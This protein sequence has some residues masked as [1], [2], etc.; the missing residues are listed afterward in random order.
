MAYVCRADGRGG[1]GR[2]APGYR[3]QRRLARPALAMILGLLATGCAS[4]PLG[5]SP[6]AARG[7]FELEHDAFDGAATDYVLEFL[8]RRGPD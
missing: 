4:A 6:T 5:G 3:R 2:E 7:R 8:S 1:S